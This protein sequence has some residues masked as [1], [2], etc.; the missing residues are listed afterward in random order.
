MKYDPET[1]MNRMTELG[2]ELST[3]NDD[4][5]NLGEEMAMAEREYNVKNKQEI[6]QLRADQYSVTLSEKIARGT[7]EVANA[8]LNFRI[9]EVKYR[10]SKN[11]LEMIKTKMNAL[12]SFLAFLRAEMERS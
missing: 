11:K 2:R 7:P 6:L 9:A 8:L 5:Q 10:S 3:E 1:L 12:Q 4:F